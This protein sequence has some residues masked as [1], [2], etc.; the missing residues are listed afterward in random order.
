MM[1]APKF[2]YYAARTAKD[3]V[4][5]LAGDER[6]MLLAGGTDLVPNMKRRQMAPKTLVSLR[7]IKELKA[8]G[9]TLGAGTTLTEIVWSHAPLPRAAAL[10][11]RHD[12]PGLSEES[13]ELAR[14]LRRWGM[15]FVG[16]TTV[17]AFMQSAGLVD[18]H[19][20]G[21]HR[22][23]SGA[24]ARRAVARP[25]KLLPAATKPKPAKRA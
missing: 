7:N 1:R 25:A 6:A 4:K 23:G 24:S 9:S 2:R 10:G 19:L 13:I 20:A 22:A 12:V 3:A 5:A 21:C 14:A 15:R 16:P 8:N 18:D 11:A 17:Y